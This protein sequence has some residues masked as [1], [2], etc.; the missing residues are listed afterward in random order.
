MG[1]GLIGSTIS[2]IS[3]LIS[4]FRHLSTHLVQSLHL[5]Q[6]SHFRPHYSHKSKEGGLINGYKNI[7]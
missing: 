1:I 6:S 3:V 4:N 5:K 2:T 7:Y